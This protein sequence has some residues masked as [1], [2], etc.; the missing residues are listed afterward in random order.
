ME[1]M[2]MKVP[3]LQ[4]LVH[5]FKALYQPLKLIAWSATPGPDSHL[6]GKLLADT[7]LD[8]M[9]CNG[10]KLLAL[11]AHDLEL[12]LHSFHLSLDALLQRRGVGRA[13]ATQAA[14][15]DDA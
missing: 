9:L 12:I 5:R 11:L 7:I 6:C 15:G 2:M 4:S 8:P 3:S 13:Q 10:T 14:F 1:M